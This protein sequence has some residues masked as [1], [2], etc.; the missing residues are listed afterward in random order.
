MKK[1]TLSIMATLA[2]SGAFLTSPIQIVKADQSTD[3]DTEFLEVLNKPGYQELLGFL[4]TQGLDEFYSQLY[5]ELFPKK[6]FKKTLKDFKMKTTDVIKDQ[7][8]S[9]V[10]AYFQMYAPVPLDEQ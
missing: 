8:I 1:F 5:L 6:D 7:V 2:L 4:Q 9:E 10:N 3:L